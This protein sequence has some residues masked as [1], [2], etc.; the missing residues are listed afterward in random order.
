[1]CECECVSVC[2]CACLCVCDCE[3]IL[4]ISVSQ[5]LLCVRVCPVISHPT[6]AQEYL[7]TNSHCRGVLA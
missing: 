3:C 1:M 6:Y 5:L 2:V 4:F 7:H